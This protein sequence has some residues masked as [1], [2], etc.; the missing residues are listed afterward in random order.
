MPLGVD[1]WFERNVEGTQL[2]GESAN[3]IA[4]DWDDKT[5]IQGAKGEVELQFHAVQH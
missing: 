1:A 3:V 5:I 2:K 4:M